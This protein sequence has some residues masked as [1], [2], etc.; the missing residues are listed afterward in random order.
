MLCRRKA[1]LSPDEL[2]ERAATAQREP[3]A[4]RPDPEEAAAR[5]DTCCRVDAALVGR[6]DRYQT[7]LLHEDGLGLPPKPSRTR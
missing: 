7:A 2:L 1:P 6:P 5:A 4:A 3:A